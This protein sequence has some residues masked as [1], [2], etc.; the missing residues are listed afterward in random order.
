MCKSALV[1]KFLNKSLKKRKFP[2][3]LGWF[4]CIFIGSISYDDMVI[5]YFNGLFHLSSY[6]H[7]GT[8]MGN[9]FAM[10][11]LMPF[12]LIMHGRIPETRTAVERERER[13]I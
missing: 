11:F 5:G 10:L 8:W 7:P 2:L 9:L 13:E 3:T 12:I 1:Q 4:C 6:I